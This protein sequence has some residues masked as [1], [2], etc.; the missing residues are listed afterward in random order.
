[1][2]RIKDLVSKGVRLIVVE[3]QPST[4]QAP[5]H[6]RDIP[7]VYD[8]AGVTLPPHGYGVDKVAEMLQSKRLATL[9]REVKA[10]AVMAA[11]EAAG[12]PVRD[13]IQDGVRRDAALDAFE[14]AKETELRELQ[15]QSAA[16]VQAIKE[17]ID[18]F[19]RAKN[20]EIEEL[21]QATEGAEK[22]FASL[23]TKKRSEEERI[24]EV[25]AHFIEGAE[26]PITTGPRPAAPASPPAKPS[27]S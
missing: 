3:D 26:N 17:E 4:P 22:A 8:E 25:V 21:K 5:P 6:E 14:S 7:A 9:G 15:R 10:T 11:L 20:A 1:M 13:V 24:H 18:G 2:S 16:R 19:L 23:Q 27:G 12:A